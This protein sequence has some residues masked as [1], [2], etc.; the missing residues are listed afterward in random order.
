MKTLLSL[1][2]VWVFLA[3]PAFAAPRKQQ[4]SGGIASLSFYLPQ[5]VEWEEKTDP[6]LARGGITQWVVAGYSARDTPAKVLYQKMLPA[7]APA[8]LRKLIH[9]SLQ[10]CKDSSIGTFK[11]SSKYH[12]QINVETICS[13]LGHERF[14]V[15]SFISIFSDTESNHLV[16]AEVR[17]PPS[18]RAG[19]L[20]GTNMVTRQ[21]AQTSKVFSDLL[22]RLMQTIRV[23]DA[24]QVCI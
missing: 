17:T 8:T 21:Q 18:S 3:S 15:Q 9:H 23:C 10:S 13:Q 5:E 1:L 14:G 16:I 20:E 22:F 19:V 24:N 4:A 2:L 12:D 6:N 11:G 7:K